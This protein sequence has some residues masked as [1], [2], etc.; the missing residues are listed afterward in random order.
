MTTTKED[1][2]FGNEYITFSDVLLLPSYSEVLP[3]GVNTSLSFLGDLV[4]GIPLFSAAMDTVT[5]HKMAIKIAQ[6]GGIGCIHKNFTIDEQ[7]DQ[8]RKVKRYE[9]GIITDPILIRNTSTV[10]DAISLMLQYGI[11]GMPVIDENDALVGIVT[12]RDIRF[13]TDTS[14]KVCD[15]MTSSVITISAGFSV[16]EAKALMQKHKIEKLVIA[17]GN[18]CKGMI[19]ARDLEKSRKYPL[20]TKDADGRLAVA[21]AVGVGG[22]EFDRASA[23]VESGCDVIVIDTAHGHSKGVIEMVK[24]IR[25]TFPQIKIVAGNVATPEAVKDL[26]KAGADCVKVGIGPGSICTTRVIAGIGVPQL[27]AIYHCAAE[28]KK[29]NVKI[30]ADGGIRNS[31]D[32]V[33]ALAAGAD[34]V[35][36][37]SLLA[38]T[39]ES[40]GEIVIYDNV[41]YKEYRGMG[42]VGAMA[43]GSADRYFQGGTQQNKFVPEG[44]EGVVPYKGHV[45]DIIHQLIGGLKSGMGYIGAATLTE[46]YTRAN[47]IRISGSSLK[48]SHPHNIKITKDAPNYS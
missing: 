12:N 44:I 3:S 4:L 35:M 21:A 9:S 38:G 37:G 22:S 39:D 27:S 25:K 30:I 17:D 24:L 41:T 32:I 31:G 14:C 28:A 11:S 43:R 45:E 1:I 26:S 15:I 47:F 5:E 48:E 19:T 6:N 18:R 10:N 2:F 40:P 46:L 8:V 34:C 36:L 33:K 29:R 23:L 7:C 16:S 13:V 42:S 20:S